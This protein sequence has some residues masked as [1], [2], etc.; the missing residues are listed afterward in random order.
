MRNSKGIREY[1]QKVPEKNIDKF[2]NEVI[3]GITTRHADHSMSEIEYKNLLEICREIVGIDEEEI[4]MLRKS[5]EESNR[6]INLMSKQ[7]N[8]KVSIP[9]ETRR[10]IILENISKY[11]FKGFKVMAVLGSVYIIYSLINKKSD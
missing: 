5:G 6:E 11:F 10:K 4:K 8:M 2:I 1:F 3:V 9:I 7:N